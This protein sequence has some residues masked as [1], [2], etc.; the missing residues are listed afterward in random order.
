MNPAAANHG[1]FFCKKE[2][3]VRRCVISGLLVSYD[4]STTKLLQVFSGAGVA[5]T[6]CSAV[7]SATTRELLGYFVF[8]LLT[9]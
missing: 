9:S 5:T 4:Q 1:Q 6:F 8:R 2:N 3:F 7:T